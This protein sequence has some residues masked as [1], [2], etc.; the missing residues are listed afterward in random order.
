MAEWLTPTVAIALMYLGAVPSVAIIYVLYEH[1]HNPGVPWFLALMGI[2]TVWAVLFATFTLVRSPAITLALANLFWA[3]VPSTAVA[4]FLLAYEYVFRTVA[5]RRLISALFAP[6][7]V[8]FLLSW[9]N[10]GNLVFTSAYGIGPDGFL[11]VPPLGGP[12]KILVTKVYGYLLASFAAGMFVGEALR[13]RG[14]RRRQTLYLLVILC[15]LAATTL[16]K[17]VG[18]VP[19]YF[20]PTSAAYS[21]SGLLFAYSIEKHGLLKFASVARDQAF[22]E[23]KDVIVVVDPD[24]VVVEIN[25]AGSDLLGEAVLGKPLAEV[26][27]DPSES[28]GETHGR[29][30]ALDGADGRRYFSEQTSRIPY[31]RGDPGQLVVLREITDLKQ[32]QDELSLLKQ[33]LVRVFRHN[34]RNDFNVIEGYASEIRQRGDGRITEM[35]ATIQERARHLQQESEKARELE[36]FFGDEDP[37]AVSLRDE[38]DGIVSR[39][40]DRSD[41]VIRQS[42]DD[43]TVLVDPKFGLAL[44][45]LVDNAITHHESA[46]PVEITISTECDD[47]LVVLTFED[48]GQGI[49][50]EE[51]RVL[52]AGE[53]TNLQHSSGIGLWLVQLIVTRPGGKLHIDSGPE[54]A[55][56]ELHLPRGDDAD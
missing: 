4:M 41:V 32:R 36:T 50:G 19:E 43:V 24:D 49:P 2:T 53:E 22:Q 51:I 23:V 30:V 42:V 31:G 45:E 15:A 8:L 7:A 29:T 25:R 16:I 11:Y 20:D 46:G 18:L 5:S 13:T 6:V 52:D 28:P 44:D 38:I 12:V 3:A 54:G 26:L 27:P 47:D 9:S 56:I 37:V 34:M 39:Y 40:E 55:R 48:N 1:R 21:V 33:I 17:I 35:A 14:V 10:P